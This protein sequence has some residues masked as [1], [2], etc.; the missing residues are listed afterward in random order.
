[1]QRQKRVSATWTLVEPATDV[2]PRPI[3]YHASDIAHD[4]LYVYGGL[5]TY[6]STSADLFVFDFTTSNDTA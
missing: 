3:A 4:K 1:M 2:V 5:L 6:Y